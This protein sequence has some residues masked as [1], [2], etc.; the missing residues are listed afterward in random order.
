MVAALLVLIAGGTSLSNQFAAIA[1]QI[2]GKV[3][4]AVQLMETRETVSL[5]GDERFPTQSVYK[6]PISM[7]VLHAVEKG[8]FSLSKR[9]S[10]RER[11]LVPF[12]HSP[13]REASPHGRTI[14]VSELIKA[15]VVESD[16]TA[17]DVLM[18]LAGGAKP[19]TAYLRS[20]GVDAFTVAATEREQLENDQVQYRNWST[21]KGAKIGRAHV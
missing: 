1:R 9:I 21:P 2:D 18:R 4:V 11:D 7:A 5:N 14:T 6:V 8:R 16:G 13:I 19:I 3:G 12:I 17:S 20:V 10:I 15:A